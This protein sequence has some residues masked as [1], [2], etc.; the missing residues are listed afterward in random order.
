MVVLSGIEKLEKD[1]LEIFDGDP[2]CIGDFDL[3]T[4]DFLIQFPIGE[5]FF[6]LGRCS[7]TLS[8]EGLPITYMGSP[9]QTG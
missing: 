3:R 2:L 5:L 8:N 1:P 9:G 4:V 7:V 6:P